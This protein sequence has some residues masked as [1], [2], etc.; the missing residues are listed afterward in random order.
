MDYRKQ[1]ASSQEIRRSPPRLIRPAIPTDSA[2]NEPEIIRTRTFKETFRP[3]KHRG[4]RSYTTPE[5][6]GP[7]SKRG[8]YLV[9]TVRV[10]KTHGGITP[11]Y[12]S[13]IYCT[14]YRVNYLSLRKFTDDYSISEN[15]INATPTNLTGGSVRLVVTTNRTERISKSRPCSRNAREEMYPFRHSVLR[16][17][18]RYVCWLGVFVLHVRE[19]IGA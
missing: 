11:F 5:A 4:T 7:F 16:Y 9:W 12:E 19:C 13:R 6:A 2:A 17:S 15:L 18:F 3:K 10:L 8:R 14:A 1:N